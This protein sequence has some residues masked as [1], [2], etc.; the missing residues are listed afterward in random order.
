MD[1]GFLENFGKQRL[2]IAGEVGI[3]EYIW[4]ATHRI[5]PEAPVPVVEVDSISHRLGLAGNVA[6]N[7]ASLGA[8]T[9]LVSVRGNDADGQ[10]LEDMLQS[11]GI[12]RTLFTEDGTRPTLRKVRVLAQK[13]HLV[14]I[15]YERTH[16]LD[17]TYCKAFTDRICDE[18]PKC[19]GI[20]LQD[21]AKGIWN[22]DTM[23]FLKHAHAHGKPVFVDPNR[24]T[25]LA[26]YRGVT[27]LSP[28]SA[29]AE[30]L[31]GLPNLAPQTAATDKERLARLAHQILRGTD[32]P[33]VVITCGAEG[34]VA[35]S[36]NAPELIHIPT[37]SRNVF[38]VTGAGD[39]VIAVLSLMYL[40]GHP[41]KTCMQVANAAAGLVV[42]Q[43]GA[44][45]VTREELKQEL[46]RLADVGLLVD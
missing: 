18:L 44:A 24:Q 36:R 1:F 28:N 9:T 14:R 10:K 27:L 29:E 30:T 45:T 38:D 37:F 8:D 32:A 43:V 6:Q 35:A 17:A 20:I 15:D 4:G 7:V 31:C 21:Y 42:A 26:L 2:L 5:S 3:D 41:L 19:D 40:Q 46:E 12:R 22:P 39:T 11:A 33:H 25:P 16:S 23:V 13:Q 34:M